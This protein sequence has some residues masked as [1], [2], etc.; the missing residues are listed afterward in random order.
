MHTLS[1][2][3]AVFTGHDLAVWVKDVNGLTQPVCDLVCQWLVANKH[4]VCIAAPSGSLSAAERFPDDDDS[5][6]Q[7]PPP[8]SF[9]DEAG[10]SSSHAAAAVAHK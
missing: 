8:S 4:V 9:Q 2:Y 10:T 7:L 1:T 5:L 6:F 3:S